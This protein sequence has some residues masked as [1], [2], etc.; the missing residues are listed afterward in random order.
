[1]TGKLTFTA[2]SE[3]YLE[4]LAENLSIPESRYESAERSYVALGE[5]LHREA[6]S[7][8]KLDP[9]VYVQG[10]FRLATTIRPLNEEEEYDVDSVC[11]LRALTKSEVTQKQLKELM[12]VEVEAY[13]K[14][15]NMSKALREGR[16]CWVLSYADGAQFHM[17]IVPA[18]PDP[19]R[20][21]AVLEARGLDARWTSTAIAI[22]DNEGPAYAVLAEDWPRSNPKGYSE[23]FKSRMASF[24]EEQRRR[25]SKSVTAGVEKVPDYRVRTPLQAAIMILKRHRDV[26]FESRADVRPISIIITTLAAHAYNGEGSI[27]RALASILDGMDRNI[28]RRGAVFWI[29]NPTDQLENFADKWEKHPERGSA[30]FE[31]LAAARADFGRAANSS[32]RQFIVEAMSKSVREVPGGLGSGG[33]AKSQTLLREGTA[34]PA[35]AGLSFPDSSRAPTKPE[36][37]GRG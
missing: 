18:V 33:G 29:P 36:G 12:R 8:R 9:R 1:M 23:W 16:R 2:E 17:D 26:M 22:T 30:F 7:V 32:D 34:A 11:E 15:Q 10:S 28:E 27:G 21:R 13:R 20:A 5:W 35:A 31:W 19:Q 37:F 24:W 3:A 25:I 6:S 4:A 14:S